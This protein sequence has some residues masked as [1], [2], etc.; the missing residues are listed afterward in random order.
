MSALIVVAIGGIYLIFFIGISFLQMVDGL[1]K[2]FR[3]GWI[4][5]G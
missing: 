3:Q 4:W 2:S 5:N 1:V